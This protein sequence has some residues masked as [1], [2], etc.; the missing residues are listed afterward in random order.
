MAAFDDRVARALSPRSRRRR[1]RRRRLFLDFS[2]SD[3][4]AV[5]PPRR[6]VFAPRLLLRFDIGPTRP[7]GTIPGIPTAPPPP[8]NPSSDAMSGASCDSPGG[9]DAAPP[10]STSR[11]NAATSSVAVAVAVADALT[12]VGAAIA[13]ASNVGLLNAP[14]PAPAPPPKPRRLFTSP[15]TSSSS[16]P[17]S[18][19]A[20][21]DI[22][23]FIAMPVPAESSPNPNPNPPPPRPATCPSPG[24]PSSACMSSKISSSDFPASASPCISA[25]VAPP[26]N[27]LASRASSTSVSASVSSSVVVAPY[28]LSS[29]SSFSPFRGVFGAFPS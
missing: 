15:M 21:F 7:P 2:P 20:L 13:S 19:A 11:I 24:I 8:P 29:A 22:V 27:A 12:G 14:P 3:S 6:F 26:N 25:A 10:I 1:S 16:S 18:Y 23:I 17:A 9:A 28:A 5:P 4:R